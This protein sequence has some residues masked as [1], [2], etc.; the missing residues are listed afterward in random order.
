M[1]HNHDLSHLSAFLELEY[2]KLEDGDRGK[3]LLGLHLWGLDLPEAKIAY[4]NVQKIGSGIVPN[5]S[6][7]KAQGHFTQ[8]R[9]F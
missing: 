8:L 4:I 7:A 2:Q 3:V 6:G 5:P 9:E 1:P